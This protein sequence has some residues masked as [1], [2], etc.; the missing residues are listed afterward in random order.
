MTSKQRF[1]AIVLIVAT[2]IALFAWQD[3]QS[4]Q[5]IGREACEMLHGVGN[6]VRRDGKWVG[7][8]TRPQ[9]TDY[10][11]DNDYTDRWC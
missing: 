9:G 4:R 10:C 2:V 7:E 6:C 1:W 3:H 5:T 8:G 11:P